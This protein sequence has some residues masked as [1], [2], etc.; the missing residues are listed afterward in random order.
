MAARRV[1]FYVQHLLGI[2][3]LKRAVVLADA[4]T[5]A[6][7]EVTLVTGGM[8]VPGLK[9]SVAHCVQLP[10]AS[11]ADL[12]FKTLL[13]AHGQPVDDTWK[14]LRREQLL[15]AW[16]A[17]NPD[18]LVIELFPFGRRQMRFELLPLL[19]AARARSPRPWI[20]SSVRDVLGGGQS[21]PARADQMLE[22]FDRYFDR[23]LVHGD[24]AWVPF[25]RSFRHAARLADRLHYTGYVVGPRPGT[26]AGPAVPRAGRGPDAEVLVSVGGGAVGQHLLETALQ[27]RPLT[28]LGANPWRLLAGI[29]ATD[30]DLARLHA[31]AGTQP[32]ICIERFR[33]DFMDLLAQCRV[34]VSQG[35]YNTVMEILQTEAAAVIVPFAGGAETEQALRAR[36]LAD[37]G[38]VRC[39]DEATLTP[40]ALAQAIDAAARWQA[41]GRLPVDLDGARATAALLCQ[42]LDG[43]AP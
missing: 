26:V 4:M 32:G 34:S 28:A 2:G 22:T 40:V 29:N 31:L 19:E 37:A 35:G 20:L 39:V 9:M 41:D 43:P 18:A 17:R 38:R 6:G 3:H 5:Q 36:L 23:V 11:A 14:A 12:G 13:D 30:A 42:W 7:L 10:P 33:P 1:F 25:G 15:A 21:D 16:S 27:A 24:G 8:P